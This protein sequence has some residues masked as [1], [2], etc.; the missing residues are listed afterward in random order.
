MG[1]TSFWKVSIGR[2]GSMKLRKAVWILIFGFASLLPAI[3]VCQNADKQAKAEF[4]RGIKLYKQGSF[5]EA[6]VAFRHADELKP[7]WS[8]YYNIA[9]SEAA[10]K[11]YGPAYEAFEEYLARG[12]DELTNA[13]RTQVINE[14]NNLK[15]FIGSLEVTAP[16]GCDVIVDGFKRGT[17]PLPGKLKISIADIHSI[18]IIKGDVVLASEKIKVSQGETA[19]LEVGE[20]RPPTENTGAKATTPTE[21]A[22][23]QKA[24][25]SKTDKKKKT[26]LIRILGWAGVGVGVAALGAGAATGGIALSKSRDLESA[27]V[28]NICPADKRDEKDSKD[29]SALSSDVLI[30]VGAVVTGAGAALLIWSYLSKK[31]RTEKQTVWV[32]PAVGDSTAALAVSGRF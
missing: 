23:P 26:P 28:E 31:N 25:S 14:L 17:A 13:R 29:A 2:E 7:A 1:V 16:E 27:C 9:Q 12:G 32:T 30:G 5:K 3:G 4:E 22:P 6:A 8:L 11:D 24:T 10:A 18:Q 20:P 21:S 19:V 15:N